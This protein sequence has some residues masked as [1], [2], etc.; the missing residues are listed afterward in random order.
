MYIKHCAVNARSSFR[1]V[2]NSCWRYTGSV[3]QPQDRVHFANQTNSETLQVIGLSSPGLKLFNG[4]LHSKVDWV[5][6]QCSIQLGGCRRNNKIGLV[7]LQEFADLRLFLLQLKLRLLARIPSTLQ[8]RQEGILRG[9]GQVYH[10][11]TVSSW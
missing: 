10:Y 8:G 7:L 1:K 4:P 11:V 9:R 5:L 3:G 6:K 2:R